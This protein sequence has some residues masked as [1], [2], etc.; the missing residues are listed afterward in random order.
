M[1]QSPEETLVNGGGG[2]GGGLKWDTCGN[3]AD[4]TAVESSLY[5]SHTSLFLYT[6]SWVHTQHSIESNHSISVKPL[7]IFSR[8]KITGS[9]S[10]T[11]AGFISAEIEK[12][13]LSVR[14]FCKKSG[15]FICHGATDQL[16]DVCIIMREIV[17]GKK[18]GKSRQLV[19]VKHQPEERRWCQS[20]MHLVINLFGFSGKWRGRRRQAQVLMQSQSHY[21]KSQDIRALFDY[22]KACTREPFIVDL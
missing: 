3:P 15:L 5:A 2:G 6:R 20:D 10:L 19:L 22:F 14:P 21:L 12:V 17:L 8:C 9:P 11:R 13:F 16:W 1:L 4:D 18:G 7:F